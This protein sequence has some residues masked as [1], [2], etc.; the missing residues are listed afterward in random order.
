MMCFKMVFTVAVIFAVSG[1]YFTRPFQFGDLKP[2]SGLALC[3]LSQF[4]VYRQR[5]KT[6]QDIAE[7]D[8][9]GLERT[10]EKCLVL[11]EH[12]SMWHHFIPV[13][14]AANSL[15][16]NLIDTIGAH[17]KAVKLMN[18]HISDTE[19]LS[20]HVSTFMIFLW[21]LFGGFLLIER[22]HYGNSSL[23][24]GA[25]FAV[26]ACYYEGSHALTRITLAAFGVVKGAQ[27][28]RL[29]VHFFNSGSDATVMHERIKDRQWNEWTLDRVEKFF[30]R[31]V[32]EFE[33][34]TMDLSFS[35]REDHFSLAASV[36][37]QRSSAFLRSVASSSRIVFQSLSFTA[38]LGRIFFI[39]GKDA[40]EKTTL[41]RMLAM[42][43]VPYE[44]KIISPPMLRS[45]YVDSV[46]HILP[47]GLVANLHFGAV[48]TSAFAWRVG[49]RVGIKMVDGKDKEAIGEI[50]ALRVAVARVRTPVNN[51]E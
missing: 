1:E 3:A 29:I 9:N 14:Q 28:C 45:A 21:L 16:L 7:F 30:A 23:S 2:L 27:S 25:F 33:E 26:L 48:V 10:E 20:E 22:E 6:Y 41:A 18:L 37:K 13:T 42:I 40:L 34:V 35:S 44:G 11:F 46:P 49:R 47:G 15:K 4:L 17:G 5:A 50:D 43:D 19:C 38:E 39:S 32:I 31:P 8:I 36:A 12:G 24:V 51:F